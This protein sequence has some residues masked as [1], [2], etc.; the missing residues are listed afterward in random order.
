MARNFEE[1]IYRALGS[2]AIGARKRHNSGGSYEHEFG[3][4]Y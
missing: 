2:M 1:R 4:K 3:P